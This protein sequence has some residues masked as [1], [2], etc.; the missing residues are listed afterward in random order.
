[1]SYLTLEQKSTYSKNGYVVIKNIFNSEEL[2]NIIEEMNSIFIT[3]LTLLRLECN[4]NFGEESLFNNMK[5]LLSNDIKRYLDCTRHIPKLLSLQSLTS[6][7]TM[8]KLTKEFGFKS[9][10]SPTTPVIHIASEQLKI[11]NGYFG[12]EEHQDW[13]SIQGALSSIVVWIPFMDILT[14]TY[15]LEILPKS[16]LNGVLKGEVDSNSY[17]IDKSLINEHDFI[18]PTLKLGDIVVMSVFTVH[19]TAISNCNGFRLACSMRY[20][21]STEETF[22]NRGFPCA[23]Q[24]TVNRSFITKDFPQ[25]P[26]L[27]KIIPFTDSLTHFTKK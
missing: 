13:T 12:V 1:M 21:D 5:T 10:T 11:P 24:R 2:E 3:Q 20:E 7:I 26:D 22:I 4:L 18:R 14:T 25:N 16:H 19:R 8:Q 27:P 9:V 15:P 23:Y 6:N 17:T